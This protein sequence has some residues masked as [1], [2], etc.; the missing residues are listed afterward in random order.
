MPFVE[1]SGEEHAR[2][3]T[4]QAIGRAS[5]SW[6]LGRMLLAVFLVCSA[7]WVAVIAWLLRL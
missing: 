4:S 6:P 3:A 1:S 7:V 5:A 2:V